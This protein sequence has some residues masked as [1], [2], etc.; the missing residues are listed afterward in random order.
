MNPGVKTGNFAVQS[1]PWQERLAL[2]VDTMREMSRQ[3]EPQAMVRAYRARIRQIMPSDR[4]LSLSRRDLAAP[5]YRITR[6]STWP[7]E[8]N[9][10]KEKDRLP[11]L[12]G[13]LLAELIYGDEPRIIDDLWVPE[14]DPAAEYLA[15]Q[16]SLL[17]IP[18]YDQ[19]V[20]LNMVIQ[21]RREPRAFDRDQLPQTVW[22][23]NLFG[24]ATHNLV[25]AEELQQAYNAVDREMQVVADIQRSLLPAQLPRIPTLDLAVSYQTASRAGGDYYDFFPLP[26]GRWGILIADVSG[27]G[28][29]AAV[30]MAVTHAIAHT[31]PGPAM[32][33]GQL[34]SYVN[35]HL[36]MRYTA[37]ADTFVTAFYGIYDPARRCL[38]YARAGHNPPRLK[39]CAD[40]TLASLDGVSGL[41]LG[42]S[43]SETYPE[44]SQQ[45]FPGDQVVFYTDG[46]TEARNPGGE[47]FGLARLDQVVSDCSHVA[48]DLLNAVL[49]AVE[50]FTAGRSADDDRTLLVARIS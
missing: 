9:P 25:L 23:S 45:L 33:P 8:I 18:M 22:L 11:L 7:Q 19:G 40:Q 16:G 47:M 6:S 21:M 48:A 14:D 10:W 4:S 35:H 29:P 24:R 44:G 50:G 36:A 15:G 13:G 41:P 3:T 43:A 31:H 49:D 42:I 30:L 46:I 39:R 5:Q 2:I 37:H 1:G 34:L 12:A 32:L 20:A 28:T 17:A 26:E 27:H 38:S